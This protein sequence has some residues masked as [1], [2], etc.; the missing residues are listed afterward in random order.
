MCYISSTLGVDIIG[1]G[2]DPLAICIMPT[3]TVPRTASAA[4]AGEERRYALD[5]R[6]KGVS[7]RGRRP[8]TFLQPDLELR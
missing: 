5:P 1:L 3:L 8:T 6:L 7:P 4:V 2:M